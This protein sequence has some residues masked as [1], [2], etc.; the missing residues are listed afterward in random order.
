MSKLSNKAVSMKLSGINFSMIAIAL[1]AFSF[2]SCKGDG[3]N[4]A[5]GQSKGGR[6]R[7][8]S[9]EAYIVTPQ[10]FS[11]TYTASG[12]L[13]PNEEIEVHPEM[14]G[15]V[16]SISFH[17][18]S[19]VHKGQ[20]LIQLYDADLRAQLQRL[21][22]QKRLQQST[23]NRQRELVSIGGISKQD[24]EATQTQM[25]YIDADIAVAEAALS[26]MRVLAP[27]DGTIGLRNVSV[28]A[29]ISPATVI[30]TLQQVHPLK[31]DFSVPDQYRSQ[32]RVGQEVLFSVD[33]TSDTLSG[34]ISAIEPGADAMT[35][36]IK[37]RAIVPNAKG[38]LNAGGFAH[39]VI[40]F[41]VNKEAILIPTQSII[42][43]TRDK[44]VALVRNGQADLVVV[45][46][47]DRTSGKI[48]ILQGLQRGD[49]I[50]TTALMQVKQG[51]TVKVRKV[52]M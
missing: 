3:K 12:S 17:E 32:M 46:T 5:K 47:G 1:A 6:S 35:R 7:N 11:N 29:V 51:D 40:P 27:F 20:L 39:V 49:T 15:R 26:K 8:V 38:K 45:K 31:M 9:A 21:Q 18:G 13:R 36:T 28:G 44:K 2:S 48:E 24:F 34:T 10:V 52:M 42:P 14:S 43:T 37:T 41:S 33:G 16:T 50:L 4:D 25:K 23:E 19:V 22:A 30:A